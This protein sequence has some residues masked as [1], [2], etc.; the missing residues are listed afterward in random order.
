MF[1]KG[2]FFV[3]IQVLDAQ[4]GD[5]GYKVADSLRQ[6]AKKTGILPVATPDAHYPRRGDA[7][8]QRVLL[9]TSL[10]K[11]IDERCNYRPFC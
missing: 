10:K 7:D 4:E 1:G 9:S 6:I 11:S 3:E 2:N 8:D 5:I